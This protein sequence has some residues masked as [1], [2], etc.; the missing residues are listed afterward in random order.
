VVIVLAVVQ[1]Y[2][3]LAMNE[4]L[5]AQFTSMEVKVALDHIG[6]LKALGPDVLQKILAYHGRHGS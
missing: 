6:D 1:P 5:T 3:T 2:V 4:C